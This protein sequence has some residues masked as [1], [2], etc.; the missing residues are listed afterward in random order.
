MATAGTVSATA[1]LGAS[2]NWGAAVATFR[3]GFTGPPPP[4][5]LTISKTHTGTFAQGQV[6]AT[7]TLTV[8]N[9]AGSGPTT[10]TVIVSDTYRRA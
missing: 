5:D 2:D 8:T 6:G 10:G 3:A 1:T 9:Q 4:P 7:Y